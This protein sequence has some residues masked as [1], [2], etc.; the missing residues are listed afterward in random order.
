[1]N[2]ENYPNVATFA[3]LPGASVET[4]LETIECPVVVPTADNEEHDS[5]TL[6]VDE[7]SKI[8]PHV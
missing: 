6:S 3:N 2:A 4:E 5:T 1:M 8:L 7:L